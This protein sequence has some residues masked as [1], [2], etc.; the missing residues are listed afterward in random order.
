MLQ[1]LKRKEFDRRHV[2][3]EITKAKR[4]RDEK[5]AQTI[6]SQIK[7]D[8]AKER[9]HREAVRQQVARDKAEREARRQIEQQAQAMTVSSSDAITVGSDTQATSSAWLVNSALHTSTSV[10]IT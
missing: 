8:K 7:E 9:A 4:N 2:G 3:Q 6:L 1:N 10:S 5:Q